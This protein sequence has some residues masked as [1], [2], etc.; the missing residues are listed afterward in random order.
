M[1]A[2]MYCREKYADLATVHD[3]EDVKTLNKIFKDANRYPVWIGLYDDRNNWKWSI[4]D[5]SF[6]KDGETEFRSWLSTQPNEYGYFD[7]CVTTDSNGKWNDKDCKTSYN[8]ICSDVEG[9]NVTFVYININMNW[10][11]AQSYC[12]E[13]H[14]DLASVRNDL[15]NTRI[16]DMIP[17]GQFAWIG[18]FRSPWMWVDGLKPSLRYWADSEP[19][20]ATEICAVAYFGPGSSG[21]WADWNCARKTTFVCFS[22]MK[23][24]VKLKLRSSSSLDLNDPTI[25]EDILKQLKQKLVNQEENKS[26]KLSWKK[27]SDGSI[28]YTEKKEDL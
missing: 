10:T 5:S 7:Y 21:K 6:Y 12:R 28:F 19:D 11:A 22:G 25:Q 1:D 18:L 8:V 14:T 20:V 27:Q 17:G 3:M 13:H 26:F 9:Q 2:Q 15:E 23:H 24:V 16:R 4:S